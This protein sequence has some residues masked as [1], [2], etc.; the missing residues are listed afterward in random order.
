MSAASFTTGYPPKNVRHFVTRR[1]LTTAPAG[2]ATG[3]TDAATVFPVTASVFCKSHPGLRESAGHAISALSV[4][5]VGL[6]AESAH[7][8]IAQ[9]FLCETSAGLWRHGQQSHVFPPGG[10]QRATHL[11]PVRLDVGHENQTFHR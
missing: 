8:R 4:Q 10:S 9:N 3:K 6:D 2:T 5:L 1:A 11:R 7:E